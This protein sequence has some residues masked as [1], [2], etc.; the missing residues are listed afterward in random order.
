MS[1]V[2]EHLCFAALTCEASCGRGPRQS[3]Y[4]VEKQ[5]CEQTG[6]VIR[7]VMWIVCHLGSL[8]THFQSFQKL[9][10]DEAPQSRSFEF[11]HSSDISRVFHFFQSSITCALI[12]SMLLF[13][14]ELPPCDTDICKGKFFESSSGSLPSA[15]DRGAFADYRSSRSSRSSCRRGTPC[16][17][18]SPTILS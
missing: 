8:F 9:I 17:P 15:N 4:S 16:R 12:L 18:R 14:L 5:H 7:I 11:L 3:R 1:A 13:W 2:S 10:V 6:G